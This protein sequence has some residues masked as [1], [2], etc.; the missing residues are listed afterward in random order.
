M[1]KTQRDNINEQRRKTENS[2]GLW[3]VRQSVP[4]LR[5][6][7]DYVHCR[8]GEIKAYVSKC[9]VQLF[10]QISGNRK[11]TCKTIRARNRNSN[12]VYFRPWNFTDI[13]YTV[14]CCVRYVY[15]SFITFYRFKHYILCLYIVMHCTVN[16][17][18]ILLWYQVSKR[19]CYFA[20][21]SPVSFVLYFTCL[22]Y[23]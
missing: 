14:H 6:H 19:R 5:G 20:L 4:G 17:A 9:S 22:S 11:P 12:S 15:L 3:R 16:S 13:F 21:W 7:L 8:D 1:K 10:A 18:L 23:C 2:C